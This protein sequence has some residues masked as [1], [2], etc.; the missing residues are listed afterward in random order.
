MTNIYSQ[1]N[2][3]QENPTNNNLIVESDP[4]S[5]SPYD[6]LQSLR[7]YRDDIKREVQMNS[8]NLKAG[9]QKS[10]G[11]Q[12]IIGTP[13][14]TKKDACVENTIKICIYNING[15]SNEFKLLPGE[16]LIS[17]GTLN[18]LPLNEEAMNKL[19]HT[20]NE[21]S[22]V[23]SEKNINIK[24]PIYIININNILTNGSK[25]AITQK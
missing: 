6:Y 4:I 23:T 2:S 16:V 18:D 11:S 24:I 22:E 17:E 7:K 25:N 19:V 10:S 8:I 3:T 13:D 12:F 9:M 15:N 5:E 14:I 21:L 20:L 1:E